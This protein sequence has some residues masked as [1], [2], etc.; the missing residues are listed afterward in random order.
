MLDTYNAYNNMHKLWNIC[1]QMT[2]N[3]EGEKGAQT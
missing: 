2:T 1:N 3:R